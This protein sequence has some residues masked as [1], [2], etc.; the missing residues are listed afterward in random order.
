M[1]E[2]CSNYGP[3]AGVWLDGIAVPLSGDKGRFRVPELYA[4]I[5]RLQPQGLICYKS[6]LY[7]ELED[8]MAPE[9]PQVT[10]AMNNRGGKPME[11]CLTMQKHGPKAPKGALWGWLDGAEHV[12][13]DEV[14][15]MLAD[16]GSRSANL[17]LNVG[18]LPDGS[19]HPEDIAT[20]KE[21]GRRLRAKR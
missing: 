17:L 14:M 8:F 4:R 1:G 13:A 5:R 18:P 6:G 21:V 12:T 3:L 16:T 10:A 2:L 11:I 19:I 20:L 7:P 9:K 15:A